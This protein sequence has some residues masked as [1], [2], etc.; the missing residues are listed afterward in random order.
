MSSPSPLLAAHLKVDPEWLA[1]RSEPILDPGRTIVDPHHH[2][3]DR[4]GL[5]YEASELTR[6][7][8]SGH[9]VRGTVFVQCRTHYRES[10]PQWLRPVGETEYVVRIAEDIDKAH[11]LFGACAG[12]VG[13]ADLNLGAAVEKVVVA[14]VEAGRGRFRG[15]R[16]S[17]AWDANSVVYNPELGAVRYMMRSSRFR[18][19][20]ARVASMGLSFDAWVYHPQIPEVTE[21][22]R[23]CPEATIVLN[24]V[25]GPIGVGPYAADRVGVFS[26]WRE[27]MRELAGCENVFVKLGGL[28]MRI[29]GHTF[30][31][32]TM[33]PNSETLALAWRPFVETSIEL[34]GADRCMFESNFPVDKAS[35]SFAILW[36]AF[37]RLASVASDED[38]D[39]LLSATAARVYR[40]KF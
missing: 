13:H 9:K 21:L 10:G 40:L 24:H 37:K 1:L 18:D 23:A 27:A 38:Q 3:W 2:L 33:P 5:S 31:E 25:G 34:F 6:D 11:P 12:I 36:N 20:V 4:A 7:L 28:A 26:E 30:H 22:A 8:L 17:S 29:S 35:C 19:G 14:H 39:K 15:V 16:H 32:Q